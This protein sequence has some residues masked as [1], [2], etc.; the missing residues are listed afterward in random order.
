MVRLVHESPQ[1]ERVLS[2]WTLGS[3]I[4]LTLVV[5]QWWMDIYRHVHSELFGARMCLIRM[6]QQ[7]HFF[8]SQAAA[9]RK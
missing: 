3:R 5:C 8:I 2:A 1:A 7:L 4:V 6:R 9:A